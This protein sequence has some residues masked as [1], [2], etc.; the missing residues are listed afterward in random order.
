VNWKEGQKVYGWNAN[1]YKW[2]GICIYK[3]HE[4]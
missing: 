1:F 3:L 2:K 4:K